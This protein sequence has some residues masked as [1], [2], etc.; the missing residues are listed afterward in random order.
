M[1]EILIFLI[2]MFNPKI[3]L[4]ENNEY[5]YYSY[6]A[7]STNTNLSDT[8]IS[9][10]IANQSAV[11]I[12]QSGITITNSNITKSGNYSG[13]T[14]NSE[15]YGVNAAILVQ[16]GGL[17]ITGG[18]V[19]DIAKVSNAIVATNG[20]T[21]TISG[22]T[23]KTTGD[24]SARGLHATYGGIITASNVNIS[25][26]GGSCATLAT[27][28][29]E[30]TVTCTN[31][32]LSTG[33][34][35]SPLIY[36]TGSIYVTNT[37]GI[38][39]KAQVVVVEGKNSATIK[40]S[41]LKCTGN[42]NGRNDDCGV[43][44]YQSMS[45]DAATGTASFTCINSNL[46]ILSTSS[47]YNSTPFFYVTNTAANISLTNCTLT[48]VSEKFLLADEGDWGESGSN[49]GTVNLT[50]TNQKIN[51]NIIVGSSSSLTIELINSSI[52]GTINGNKNASKLAITLDANS[53]ITLTG[54]SYYTSL[55][56]SVS[57]NSNIITG[58]YS[59]SL[60]NESSNSSSSSSNSSSSGSE[61]PHDKPG[62]TDQRGNNTNIIYSSIVSTTIIKDFNET[63]SGSENETSVVLLGFSHFNK[64]DNNNSFSFNIYFVRLL[65]SILSNF[66]TFPITVTHNSNLRFLQNS[67]EINST[68]LLNGDATG[69]KVQYNCFAN[70][71]KSIAKIQIIPK[72]T[73]GGKTANLAGITSL[74]N[75]YLTNIQ[76]V[77]DQFNY[78]SSS[79]VYILDNSVYN[80]HDAGFYITGIMSDRSSNINNGDNLD[81]NITLNNSG[82]INETVAN[83]DV[84][85]IT[86][87][88]YT[89][90]CKQNENITSKNL[91]VAYSQVDNSNILLVNFAKQ[92]QEEDEETTSIRYDNKSSGGLSAGAIVAIVLVPIVALA[93]VASI[94]VFVN[95]NNSALPIAS[96]ST[97]KV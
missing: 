92:N 86:G 6:S 41:N 12:N 34:S 97:E 96:D 67:E 61:T 28:R 87:N 59:W 53:N 32:S 48:Y 84:S 60:Y 30:G 91:Q 89:L 62:G 76:D 56:N 37:T 43:L 4:T 81:L 57:N 9:C 44:I 75:N 35:G 66:L 50:L 38:A 71:T 51:G 88:N 13:K 1:K 78:L 15:F 11:Y 54:N 83:C 82:T 21:I 68:C 24:S 63:S 8:T 25:T 14:D 74:A 79:D 93:A 69:T 33:G 29:G 18:S 16:G 3:A 64:N 31:C 80:K 17:T 94:F 45:G 65:N 90:N 10:T 20:G 55:T 42:G 49:G 39:S 77:G 47:V 73:F 46:E 36:S 23:I 95:K 2:L 52:N 27:D 26:T 7:T 22:T 58:S 40:D 70:A 19:T 5:D 85:N 72:F